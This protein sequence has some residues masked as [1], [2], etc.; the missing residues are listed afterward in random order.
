MAKVF[1][2]S[3]LP[4]SGKSTLSRELSQQLG[5]PRIS[6]DETWI[7]VEN[8]NGSIP[9]ESGVDKW[10]YICNV[11][12]LKTKEYLEGGVSVVYDNLGSTVEQRSKIR[13]L[14]VEASAESEVIYVAASKEEVISRRERNLK[15]KERAQVSDEN[16]DN[17]L[18]NF[19]PPTETEK[20]RIY[21]PTQ[22]MDSWIEQEFRRSISTEHK[23]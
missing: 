11:C 13:D 2:M 19:E 1:I 17:A 4:F 10:K 6:F 23:E 7:E 16:F 5:I 12:E 21:Y 22:T 3:G 20:P 18:E 8:T 14:A 9:G 15:A